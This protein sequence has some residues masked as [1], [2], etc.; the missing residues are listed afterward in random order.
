MCAVCNVPS[1]PSMTK[2][3][4]STRLF[5]DTQNALLASVYGKIMWFSLVALFS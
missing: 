2:V 1:I 5:T 3:A 4:Y